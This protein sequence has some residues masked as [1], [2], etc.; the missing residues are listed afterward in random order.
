MSAGAL[1]LALRRATTRAAVDD[2]VER[3]LEWL[4]ATDSL[5]EAQQLSLGRYCTLFIPL[6]PFLVAQHVV[7]DAGIAQCVAKNERPLALPAGFY[8]QKLKQPASVCAEPADKAAFLGFELLSHALGA[9]DSEEQRAEMVRSV[10]AANP[11]VLPGFLAAMDALDAPEG[12]ARARHDRQDAVSATNALLSALN[13]VSPMLLTALTNAK[14][15]TRYRTLY[16][17]GARALLTCTMQ[18]S[19]DNRACGVQVGVGGAAFPAGLAPQRRFC[20]E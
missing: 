3:A 5:A 15:N 8:L 14:G 7:S 20:R 6:L 4:I 19:R 16:R 2:A 13:V 10:Y 1:A 18:C 12:P 11:S 9:A 17:G